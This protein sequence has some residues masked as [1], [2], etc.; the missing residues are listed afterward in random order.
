MPARGDPLGDELELTRRADAEGMA[1]ALLDLRA[2]GRQELGQQ[3][4]ALRRQFPVFIA[5]VEVLALRRRRPDIAHGEVLAAHL[6]LGAFEER[7]RE[8][9]GEAFIKRERHHAGA[10]KRTG[11]AIAQR[12]HERVPGHAREIRPHGPEAAQYRVVLG[13][14]LLQLMDLLS[15]LEVGKL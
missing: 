5:G 3:R 7:C 2:D 4:Q 13:A 1:D 12:R 6:R 8:P 14:V 15:Q 11:V 9:V 10:R